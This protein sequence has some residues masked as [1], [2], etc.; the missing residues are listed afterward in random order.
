MPL[1][2]REFYF[3]EEEREHMNKEPKIPVVGFLAKFKGPVSEGYTQFPLRDGDTVFVFG[4]IE[5]MP[6][7]CVVADE[8]GKVHFGYHTQDFIKLT[9]DEV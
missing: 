2:E 5:N 3:S 9:K 6:H 7:H 1:E 4:E 8:Q